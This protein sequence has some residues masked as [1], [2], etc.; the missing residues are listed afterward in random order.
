MAGIST[1]NI[2]IRNNPCTV[3]KSCGGE[4]KTTY[5]VGRRTNVPVKKAAA[6]AAT[7]CALQDATPHKIETIVKQ[8]VII[9]MNAGRPAKSMR[10]PQSGAQNM[11][12]KARPSA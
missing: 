10:T 3:P 5:F 2:K 7:C 1:R 9:P 6:I 11:P 12:T 4:N 8:I